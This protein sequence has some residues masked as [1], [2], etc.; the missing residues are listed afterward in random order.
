MSHLKQIEKIDKKKYPHIV[1]SPGNY[2][3]LKSL[4]RMGDSFDK[5]VGDLLS[6]K[7]GNG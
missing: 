6:Q 7:V 2:N 4:G 3:R 5:I 1:L